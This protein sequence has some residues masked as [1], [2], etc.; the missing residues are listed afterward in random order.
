ML[1]SSINTSSFLATGW[2]LYPSVFTIWFI[3]MLTFSLFGTILNLSLMLPIIASRKLRCGT[4]ILIAHLLLINATL[5]LIH[6]SI[7]SISTYAVAPYTDLSLSFCRHTLFWYYLSLDAVNWTFLL[8]GINQFVA[9][10]LPHSYTK[11][12]GNVIV[13]GVMVT[14]PWLIG[15]SCKLPIFNEMGCRWQPTT[16]WGTCGVRVYP[17]SVVY[18]LIVT[19]CVFSPLGALGVVYA[20]IFGGVA[21]RSVWMR[22]QKNGMSRG[23]Q[24]MF[25]RRYRNV[26]MLFVSYLWYSCCLLPAPIASS[27]FPKEYTSEMLLPLFM[28]AL[29]LFGYATI[30]VVY[31]V[32]NAEYRGHAR[33]LWSCLIDQRKTVKIIPHSEKRYALLPFP[34]FLHQGKPKP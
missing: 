34:S 2:T 28:R 29:L 16:P 4:G 33:M 12:S 13:T 14:L 1:N 26:K 18:P 25:T 31:L 17:G 11:W 32:M 10:F 30:P 8:I 20:V 22:R 21:L 23:A 9:I 27:L 3:I 15:L 6:M 5:C 24:R 19:V 7:L